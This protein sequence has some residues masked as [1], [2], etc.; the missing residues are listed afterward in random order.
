M[1]GDGELTIFDVQ[2]LFANLDTAAE[3]PRAFDST[4]DGEVGITDVQALFEKL[5]D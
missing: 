4:G 3:Y 1:R 5:T 2:A